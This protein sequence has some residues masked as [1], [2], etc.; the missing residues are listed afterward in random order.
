MTAKIHDPI[1]C[2]NCHEANTMR[3]IVTNPA[4]ETALQSQG[5]DW[6]TFSRQ[7]MRSLV[8]ANC[9]V[10][11]Y[12]AGDG[13]LLTLPW[14]D[15]TTVENF[16]QYYTEIK[17]SD[18]TH[19]DS[20]AAMVKMQHPDYELFT[21]GSTHFKAGVS[22]ADC[23]MPYLRDGAAKYSSHN[24]TS[25]LTDPAASCGAC[26]TDVNYVVDRAH[27]IQQQV[28][29][30][31][32]TTEDALVAAIKAIK[33]AAAAQG[34]DPTVLQQARDLHRSAQL[35]WDYIAAANSLG[36]HNPEEA[37][38]ILA[39]ATDLARQAQIKAMQA[40]PMKAGG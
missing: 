32:A 14:K 7:E 35:R 40:A 38:R 26:H 22:C 21:A 17:F 27:A 33:A 25:P 29:E 8:C 37:L 4:L 30:T 10:E 12:F 20:G 23:H 34:F 19:A 39:S 18:W 16:E 11:Y 2:A 1:G 36:F 24:V 6:R 13:K 15:G 5:K 9:H 31:K 28:S 3:L